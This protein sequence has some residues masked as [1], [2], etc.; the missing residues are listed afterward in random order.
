V[1]GGNAAGEAGGGIRNRGTLS[2]VNIVLAANSSESTA[3]D[4]SISAR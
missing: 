4:C 1:R 2:L 3:A